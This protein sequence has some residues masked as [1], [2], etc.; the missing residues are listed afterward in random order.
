MNKFGRYLVRKLKEEGISPNQLAHDSGLSEAHISRLSRQERNLPKIDSLIKIASA[1]KMS[2]QGMLK[3]LGYMNPVIEKLPQNLQT[4]LNSDLKPKDVNTDEIEMLALSI[5]YEDE[6][7]TSEGYLRLLEE[8][9]AQP[10]NR[11]DRVFH[12]QSL[13][14]QE[15][16]AKLVES[17]VS[18]YGDKYSDDDQS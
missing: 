11:I 3:E 8:H 7:T 18:V 5:S 1:L 12:N 10:Q 15:T 16:C 14:L 9:R 2:L 13:D 4:F 6:E 17:Y